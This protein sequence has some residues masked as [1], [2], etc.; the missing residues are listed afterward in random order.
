MKQ[1]IIKFFVL[2]AFLAVF[3]VNSAEAQKKEKKSKEKPSKEEKK[4]KKDEEKQLKA[5][6]KE[7][8]N[9]LNKYKSFKEAKETA[10]SELSSTRS[11][12]TRVKE[13]EAQCAKEVEELRSEI[14]ELQRQLVACNKKPGGF[15]IPSSGLYYVVQIGAFEQKDL[16][17][18]DNNPDF[19]KDFSQGLNKYIMG[20]FP[21]VAQADQLRDFLLQLDFKK[22]PSYRPFIAPYRDGVRITIEEALGPDEAQKRKA[23]KGENQ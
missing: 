7:F 20:V 8:T 19:R 16:S 21:S 6:L 23:Q 15:S 2:A 4:A 18:N 17:L 1:S 13:L 3:L 10:E 12:L 14:E 22:D 5:E 9:D 11:E